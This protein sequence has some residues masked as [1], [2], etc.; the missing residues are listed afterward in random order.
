MHY[1][2]FNIGDYRRDTAHLKP[3]EHYIYR[4]LVDLYYLDE[5]PISKET[6]VVTRRLSLGFDMVNDVQNV[7]KD[8]FV[9]GEKG[10]SH[11]RIDAEIMEYRAKSVK[12]RVNGKLGGRPRK[13]QVV[14][15]RLANDNRSESESN[16]NQEPITNNQEP[17]KEKDLSIS[18][19]KKEQKKTNERRLVVLAIFEFW[20]E[21]MNHPT[22]KMDAKREKAIS[23][24]LKIGYSEAE[25]KA[26]ITG[27]SQT[28]FNCGDN[29]RKTRYDGLGII[30]KS[31]D[32]IDRF[33]QNSIQPIQS[34][35]VNINS[36]ERKYKALN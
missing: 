22:A 24:A 7:L 2:N 14:S 35:V 30:F 20:Q 3:I 28:P 12:N 17:I 9:L 31:A 36:G 32:Q 34:K 13:T 4:S 21:A 27:C 8:F 15:E 10:W 19:E 25:L 6:Q 11:K 23:D 16:P 33:I 18:A 1:Y 5:K 29:D 26:A